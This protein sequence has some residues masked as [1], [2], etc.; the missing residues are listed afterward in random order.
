M[1]TPI[2]IG[3]TGPPYAVQPGIGQWGSLETD[4]VHVRDWPHTTKNDAD[5]LRHA[6]EF[7]DSKEDPE[8]HLSPVRLS[9]C[10]LH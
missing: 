2:L 6:R 1:F 3:S 9:I 10:I 7:V 4:I 8:D 5:A